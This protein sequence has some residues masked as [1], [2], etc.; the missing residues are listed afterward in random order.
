MTRRMKALSLLLLAFLLGLTACG[1]ADD[2]EPLVDPTVDPISLSVRQTVEAI[3]VAETVAALTGGDTATPEPVPPTAEP[4]ADQPTATLEIIAPTDSPTDVPT[5]TAVAAATAETPPTSAPPS[6]TTVTGVNVRSGPGTVYE[7]PLGTLAGNTTV[8]PI[9]YVARGFPQGEWLEVQ[10]P[11]NGGTVWVTAGPQFVRCTVDPTTLPG[12]AAVA[13]TPRPT[14]TPTPIPVTPTPTLVVAGLPPDVENDV[15]GGA[16]ERTDHIKTRIQEDPNFL[17]R[18]FARDDRVGENDGDGIDF[19]RFTISDGF[20][21]LYQR[22]ERTA[23]YCIWRG[24][25][26]NCFTWPFNEQGRY[27][28]GEGGPVVSSGTYQ[29]FIEVV[30]DQ[31]DP[32]TESNTC[33]WNFDMTVTVP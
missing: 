32:S 9:S 3:A 4:P 12:P 28:W 7:P 22:E 20:G 24:G 2:P 6:C 29:V 10:V 5:A 1:G 13:P 11:G 26:P 25:E 17:Y 18:V 15:P 31:P 14:A 16:C 19:V 27:T 30:S 33:N 8:T 21:T 23:G